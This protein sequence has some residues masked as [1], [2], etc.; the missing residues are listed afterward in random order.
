[1]NTAADGSSLPRR[2]T[3]RG[4]VVRAADGPSL[5]PYF[6]ISGARRCDRCG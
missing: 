4:Y 6:S 2:A 1:M 5:V 3:P